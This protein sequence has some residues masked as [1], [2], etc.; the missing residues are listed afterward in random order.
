[1]SLYSKLGPVPIRGYEYDHY[2]IY[3][4]CNTFSVYIIWKVYPTSHLYFLYKRAFRRVYTKK[5]LL[6]SGFFSM[7]YHEK[8]LHN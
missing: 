7:A 4:L 3:C 8:T 2:N 5:M 1:M 6:T